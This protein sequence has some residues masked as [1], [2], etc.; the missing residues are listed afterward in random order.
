M[1]MT[2]FMV[3]SSWRSHF[4]SSP[5]SFDECRLS[6]R[7]K[8]SNQANRLGLW[9]CHWLLPSTSTITIY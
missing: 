2:M 1:L 7:G 8:A 3:L 4:E 9:V 5:G 6:D